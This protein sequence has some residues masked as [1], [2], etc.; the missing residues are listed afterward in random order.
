MW[1][2]ERILLFRGGKCYFFF[3]GIEERPH[4]PS[5]GRAGHQTDQASLAEVPMVAEFGGL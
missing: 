4:A 3:R 2:P 1:T 5:P